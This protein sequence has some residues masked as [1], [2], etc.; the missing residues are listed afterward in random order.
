MA[1]EG[2]LLNVGRKR[3]NLT[4]QRAAGER[5]D[6]LL[7]LARRYFDG[8]LRS[9]G[10]QIQMAVRFGVNRSTICRDIAVLEGRP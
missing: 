10:L 1:A 6:V 9:R 8:D 4:R 5:R 7:R 3:W 2:L